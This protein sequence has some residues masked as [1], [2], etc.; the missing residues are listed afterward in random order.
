MSGGASGNGVALSVELAAGSDRLLE[1]WMRGGLT[2]EGA[3]GG[4]RSAP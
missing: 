4:G 2:L 1:Q 3:F